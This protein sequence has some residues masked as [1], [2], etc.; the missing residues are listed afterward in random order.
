MPLPVYLQGNSTSCIPVGPV[1]QQCVQTQRPGVWQAGQV[2]NKRT[3]MHTCVGQA[4]QEIQYG[5]SQICSWIDAC[6]LLIVKNHW[7][8]CS[9]LTSLEYDENKSIIFRPNGK[10]RD[11]SLQPGNKFLRK[12]HTH[13]PI[14][15]LFLQNSWQQLSSALW[16]L[17]KH[18]LKSTMYLQ[19][20][21]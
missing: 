7:C 18:F 11:P 2:L 12:T 8:W 4:Q 15:L 9:F 6:T 14:C 19:M 16:I 5:V 21:L 3:H 13:A 1:L 10:V 20:P 17:E